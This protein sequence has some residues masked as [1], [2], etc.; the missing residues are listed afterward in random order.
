MSK[1]K[2]REIAQGA[3]GVVVSDGV[4]V[5]KTM[6][7]DKNG[8]FT[9]EHKML[10]K[11]KG[12]EHVVQ[13][14]G[15]PDDDA[16]QQLTMAYAG[17]DLFAYRPA[18]LHQRH[19]VTR[20]LVGA[21]A[22]LHSML[23]VHLDLKLENVCVDEA[24]T[25]RLIDFGMSRVVTSLRDHLRIPMGT[26]TYMCPEMSK[27][28]PSTFE[29]ADAWALAITVYAL[30]MDAFPFKRAH[31]DNAHF[32]KYVTQ[33]SHKDGTMPLEALCCIFCPSISTS[34]IPEDV[35][36]YINAALWPDIA[37]RETRVCP[38]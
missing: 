30:W 4:L 26:L 11:L 13:V 19:S 23:M 15:D 17:L 36:A 33:L 14:V 27:V 6:R 2:D 35:R 21:V 1:R 18:S 10:W 9:K 20:Q 32:A 31:P 3:Y 25:V 12:Y 38:L 34:H 29:A 24:G 16:S 28:E 7:N 22:H 8:T 5:R 37:D